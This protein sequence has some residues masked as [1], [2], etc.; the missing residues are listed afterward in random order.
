MYVT[1]DLCQ[2]TSHDIPAMSVLTLGNLRPGI[3]S[4]LIQSNL[5]IIFSLISVW[6]GE[7]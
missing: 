6:S 5:S 1:P 2:P 7:F 3:S 4:L